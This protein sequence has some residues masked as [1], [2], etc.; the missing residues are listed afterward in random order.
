[1]VSAMLSRQA[2]NGAINRTDDGAAGE[3]GA[4]PR[5]WVCSSPGIYL[6]HGRHRFLLTEHFNT[7][8]KMLFFISD[9]LVA[10]FHRPVTQTLLFFT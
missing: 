5:G 3:R 8:M 9:E 2:S 10:G 4:L 1:M 6:V 7:C